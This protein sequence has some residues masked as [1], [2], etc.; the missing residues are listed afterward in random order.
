MFSYHD[1]KRKCRFL[2]IAESAKNI[3]TAVGK[4]SIWKGYHWYFFEQ[5]G[6]ILKLKIRYLIQCNS[7]FSISAVLEWASKNGEGTNS[8]FFNS[9]ERINI[10]QMNCS[11]SKLK[12]RR[13]SL[14][15]SF[16]RILNS[17][18][19]A[20]L[21]RWG[22]KCRSRTFVSS[23]F[24]YFST[25]FWNVQQRRFF[26]RCFLIVHFNYNHGKLS[27]NEKLS[28]QCLG[29]CLGLSLPNF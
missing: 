12:E 29:T 22:K 27:I 6:D 24:P 16:F 4:H 11:V 28:F 9:F 15:S 26:G 14:V 21:I 2:K 3:E 18:T 19:D 23:M 20:S 5:I 25:G 1:Q 17:S 13:C 8:N 7:F 10:F